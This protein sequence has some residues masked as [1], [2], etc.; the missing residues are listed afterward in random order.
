MQVGGVDGEA[1]AFAFRH[2]L[3]HLAHDVGNLALEVPDTGFTRVVGDDLSHRRL[4]DADM[5]LGN[6]MFDELP[7]DQIFLG[8]A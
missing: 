2:F 3:C 7:G 8:D 4:G 1:H 6:A 5:F